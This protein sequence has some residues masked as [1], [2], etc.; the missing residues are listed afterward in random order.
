M[1]RDKWVVV[2]FSVVDEEGSLQ[3]RGRT[4]LEHLSQLLIRPGISAHKGKAAADL[5]AVLPRELTGVA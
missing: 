4:K 5:R 1:D 2:V 3:V